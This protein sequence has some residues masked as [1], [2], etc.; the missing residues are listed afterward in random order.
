MWK[1]DQ[2]YSQ[3]GEWKLKPQSDIMR[4]SPDCQ[5]TKIDNNMCF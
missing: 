3:S 2:L 5:N 4:H 1:C